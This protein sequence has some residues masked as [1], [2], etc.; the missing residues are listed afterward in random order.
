MAPKKSESLL[1]Y[2]RNQSDYLNARDAIKNYNQ[3]FAVIQRE[4]NSTSPTSNRFPEIL[5]SYN[6]AKTRMDS[7]EK[8][9][10]DATTAGT[11]RFEAQES[12]ET[13]TKNLS[14]TSN[15]EALLN[16]LY[17]SRNAYIRQGAPVPDSIT[18]QITSLE[19]DLRAAGGRPT[20][21]V[22]GPTGPTDVTGATGV[23]GV[24]GATGVT[25][26]TESALTEDR[27]TFAQKYIGNVE[28]TK[29]LQQALKD[30]NFYRGKVDGIFR[31]PEIDAALDKADNEISK[32]ESYGITFPDRIAALK[33]LTTDFKTGGGPGGTGAGG[34]TATISNPT[35]ADAY[36]NAAFN[37]ELGRD[38]T[39]AE[40][41]KYRKILNN[42]EKK[43]PSRTVNGI[44]TGGI[45]RDQFL[46]T[47]IAKLPEFAKKKTDKVALTAQSILGTAK[48]NGVTLNQAQ[49]DSFAKRV[50]DGTDIKTIDS[51]IRGIAGLGMPEKVQKLLSQGIDL[52]TVYSPYRNLMASI[53]ELN[54]ES[55]DLKDP[56]LRSAIGP[57]KEMPIYD[58][59]KNLR[60]DFRWQY[61][62]NAKRD[63]S[64]VALKVLRDFGFQ[65]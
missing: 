5:A 7:L 14:K 41:Q 3:T 23:T 57:D 56:T 25:T 64:N 1:K 58:F 21:G 44:T 43:N 60:K 4:Y 10:E 8:A 27:I 40:L 46:K 50:Q 62:D 49:I 61:T 16:P 48:A 18:R 6:A 35:Q 63:V 36:V 20:P 13:K 38:A 54:P 59:E 17:V 12:K 33:R 11:E 24:T 29:E 51:E 19:T 32:Y 55:I 37:S 9:F 30:A 52:D 47:E 53:L 26:P 42:A 45:N 34:P 65:A 31:A 2:L 28:K 22:T 15:I 39:S